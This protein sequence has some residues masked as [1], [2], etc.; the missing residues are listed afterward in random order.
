MCRRKSCKYFIWLWDH[1]PLSSHWHGQH[2]ALS[3]YHN[4]Y[5]SSRTTHQEQAGCEEMYA[6]EERERE[7]EWTWLKMYRLCA[8]CWSAHCNI[9]HYVCTGYFR[10]SLNINLCFSSDGRRFI[11]GGKHSLMAGNNDLRYD[12]NGIALEWGHSW[13]ARRSLNGV[14]KNE[15]ASATE[16]KRKYPQTSD[17]KKRSASLYIKLPLLRHLSFRL[18]AFT[19]RWYGLYFAFQMNE[20]AERTTECVLHHSSF[21]QNDFPL[22]ASTRFA[23]QNDAAETLLAPKI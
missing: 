11:V 15:T 7:R 3:M 22:A 8:V 6:S 12:R 5:K 2:F 10:L 14:R 18:K 21:Q 20:M 16:Q 9:T 1:C 17:T 13:N 19:V 23:S 4:Q